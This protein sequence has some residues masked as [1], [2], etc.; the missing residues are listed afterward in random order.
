MYGDYFHSLDNVQLIRLYAYIAYLVQ[1]KKA[2]ADLFDKDLIIDFKRWMR[3]VNTAT[4]KH[5]QRLR[6][7]SMQS[8]TD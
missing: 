2:E 3:F 7:Q 8:R 6:R 5:G 4:G 1:A